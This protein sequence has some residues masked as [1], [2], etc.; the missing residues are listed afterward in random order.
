MGASG[1]IQE[2]GVGLVGYGYWGPNLARNFSRQDNC[3]LIAICELDQDRLDHASR[4]FPNTHITDTYQDILSNPDIHA[5]LVATPV[6]SHHP[7]VMAALAA[8][9]DVFVEKP[10]ASNMSE[11]REMVDKAEKTGRVLAV[12][13]TFLFTGAVRKAKELIESGEIGELVYIDSVR[14]NLGLFQHDVNVVFDLAPHDISIATYLTDRDPEY[15]QAVGKCYGSDDIESVAYAHFEYSDGMINHCHLSWLSPVKVRRTLITG[16]K[17]M[18]LY[19]D[20]EPSEKIKVYDQ[21][22]IKNQL[23]TNAEGRLDPDLKRSVKIDYRIGDMLA[24]K[25]VKSEALDVEAKHF[26]DC[27]RTRSQPL[28]DGKFGLRVLRQIEACLLS[29]K[30]DGKRIRLDD[31]E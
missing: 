13:H 5:V 22:I 20:M 16:T 14:V 28:S 12:D 19:D 10:L 29:L 6:F 11:G 24:P 3:T 18:I 17:K 2:I 23:N 7:L 1:E 9:K 26:L 8:G 31:V 25:L 15:I 4:D 27:V 21:G 30:Q